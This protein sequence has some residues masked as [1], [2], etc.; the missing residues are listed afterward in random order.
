MFV[1][2]LNQNKWEHLR[3]IFAFC[4]WNKDEIARL[5]ANDFTVAVVTLLESVSW[6]EHCLCWP[7]RSFVCFFRFCV[8]LLQPSLNGLT[9]VKWMGIKQ[10]KPK[11]HKHGEIQFQQISYEYRIP[12]L[13]IIHRYYP[14]IC[15][16][17]A[18]DCRNWQAMIN[19]PTVQIYYS[20][21]GNVCK[22]NLRKISSPLWFVWC[23]YRLRTYDV[24]FC[25][26][27]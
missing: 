2:N 24:A 3:Q 25:C 10:F 21:M 7:Y 22:H 18:G 8:L 6:S 16:W 26:S 27:L 12:L 19:G 1:L 23:V 5:N 9:V 20:T 11:L 17:N 15:G 13:A 14:K 4:H